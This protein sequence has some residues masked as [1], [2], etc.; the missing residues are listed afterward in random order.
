M[1]SR[2]ILTRLFCKSEISVHAQLVILIVFIIDIS[3]WHKSHSLY[4]QYMLLIKAKQQKIN[5]KIIY[6]RNEQ[7][8]N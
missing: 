6:N 4:L 8:I 3:I 5:Q 2:D 1:F 7:I